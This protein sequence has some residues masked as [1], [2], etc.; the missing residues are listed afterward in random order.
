MWNKILQ[1]FSASTTQ[2]HNVSDTYDS[3]SFLRKAT[4]EKDAGNFDEAI[5]LL[6]RAYEVTKIDGTEHSVETFLRLPLYLQKAGRNDEG[7]KEFN[8]LL[9]NGYPNQNKDLQ[10]VAM[11]NS[12]IYDKM[13]LFLQRENKNDLAIKFGVCSYVSWAV[14]LHRQNRKDE[15]EDYMSEETVEYNVEKLLKNAKKIHLKDKLVEAVKEQLTELPCI[16]FAQLSR[17]VDEIVF[18]KNKK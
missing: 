9:T 13:R 15:L 10:F 16:N 12:K 5:N 8:L 14:G 2:K 1:F 11:T 3:S 4:A 17:V 18:E 6:R 7:W